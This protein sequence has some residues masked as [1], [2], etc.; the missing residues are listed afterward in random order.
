M[1][2]AAKASLKF[3]NIDGAE[4]LLQH[5]NTM[6]FSS[7]N[8]MGSIPISFQEIKAYSDLMGLEFTPQE[9]LALRAMSEAYVY[10]SHDKSV[11]AQPPFGREKTKK[12]DSFASALANISTIK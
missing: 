3:P 8:G 7:S 10:E 12:V 2:E 11:N 1:W 5:L 4:Y 9:V 6:G